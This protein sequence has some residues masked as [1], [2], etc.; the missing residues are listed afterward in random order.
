MSN[1]QSEI[2][3]IN[4]A[5]TQKYCYDH[6]YYLNFSKGHATLDLFAGF[7]RVSNYLANQGIDLEA[8]ELLEN[9]SRHIQLPSSKIH[10]CD[11][12]EF[13]PKKT[14]N[15]IISGFNSFCLLTKDWEIKAFFTKLDSW[16]AKDGLV[17]L[18][19]YH[20]DY[21]HT[22]EKFTF[23]YKGK[24][25]FYR[26]RYDLSER[27]KGRGIWIDEFLVDGELVLIEYHTIYQRHRAI[28][29]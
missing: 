5:F 9:Y 16:L 12:L 21:W 28:F 19:Y 26:P 18:S 6:V 17:S 29:E 13:T 11:V 14:F 4:K 1:I 3:E 10:T 20:Q 7:G 25:A 24:I 2:Y 15:R 23:Q 22:I 27:K 8:V